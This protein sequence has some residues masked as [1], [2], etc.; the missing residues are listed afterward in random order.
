MHGFGLI[1]VSVLFVLLCGL[2]FGSLLI[3]EALRLHDGVD[4]NID[5]FRNAIQSR[6]IVLL[7]QAWRQA[8]IVLASQNIVLYTPY[9]A[10]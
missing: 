5:Q 9:V 6:A 1:A 4:Q 10:V 3:L 8:L 2:I 7:E